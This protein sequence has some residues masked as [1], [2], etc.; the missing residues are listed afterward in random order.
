MA[1]FRKNKK[2][3]RI[4]Y[5]KPSLIILALISIVFLF[6]IIDIAGKSKETRKNKDAALAKI[7]ELNNQQTELQS[8]IDSLQTD[9]GIEK[10][11]REKFPVI[12]DGEGLVVI[13]DEPAKP[14]DP[15]DA[16]SQGGF[17]Q[18]LKNIFT[19]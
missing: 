6:N 10:N 18:F 3:T 16:K 11:I 15:A 2:V 7:S 1:E 14:T 19:R 12:K 4:L 5:S 9:S 8:E 17:W 13:V